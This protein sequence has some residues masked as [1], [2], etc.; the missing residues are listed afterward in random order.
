MAGAIEKN[1]L[2]GASVAIVNFL[3]CFFVSHHDDY[4]Y[5]EEFGEGEY[6]YSF[7]LFIESFNLLQF[8]FNVVLNKALIISLILEYVIVVDRAEVSNQDD[9]KSP[10]SIEHFHQLLFSLN[11]PHIFH[12]IQK[13]SPSLLQHLF[14]ADISEIYRKIIASQIS[15]NK[16]AIEPVKIYMAEIK[17]NA[18]SVEAIPIPVNLPVIMVIFL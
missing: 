7:R 8:L 2:E 3:N 5:F 4:F 1:H 16:S 15:F 17:Q 11:R 18:C 10:R 6:F 12:R 13:L 9:V 14:I